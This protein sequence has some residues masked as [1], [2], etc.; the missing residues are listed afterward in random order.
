MNRLDL[1]PNFEHVSSFRFYNR[2]FDLRLPRLPKGVRLVVQRTQ[3]LQQ[4]LH[5]LG[6]FLGRIYSF[7]RSHRLCSQSVYR[8]KIRSVPIRG[9]T[10]TL[11]RVLAR[12]RNSLQEGRLL[13]PP[14]FPPYPTS[15]IKDTLHR[16]TLSLYRYFVVFHV[17]L[18]SIACP[19]PA[20][21]LTIQSF[22]FLSYLPL[23]SEHRELNVIER[24]KIAKS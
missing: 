18:L 16:F 7:Q 21:A 9:S 5:H 20:T 3:E 12:R 14:L 6:G 1:V 2:S 24:V 10:T 8:F 15:S 19:P 23:T 11:V 22:S 4:R 13:N 17:F